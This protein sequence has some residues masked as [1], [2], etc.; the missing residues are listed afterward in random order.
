[1]IEFIN[2]IK[3]YAQNAT[4]AIALIMCFTFFVLVGG[5]VQYFLN[6]K[7]TKKL[8]SNHFH[9]TNE[10]LK[11]G[12]ERIEKCLDAGF[13]RTE[14]KLNEIEKTTIY[15]KAKAENGKRK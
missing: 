7:Q 9:T 10:I 13:K 6:I 8:G 15:L 5:V 14:D 3:Q 2:L 1:M 11:D 4:E 12:F